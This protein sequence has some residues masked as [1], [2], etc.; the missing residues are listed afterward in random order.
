MN[1]SVLFA[2]LAALATVEGRQQ[3]PAR[4]QSKA[5]DWNSLKPAPTRTGERRDVF[6][7]PTA[8]LDKLHGHITT[9][10]PGE[11]TGPLHR[12]RRRS[13]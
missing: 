1:R 8:T 5:I 13:W 12:H 7:A 11:H 10:N 2:V 3:T 4:L 9:L 6:D